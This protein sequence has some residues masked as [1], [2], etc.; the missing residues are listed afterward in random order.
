MEIDLALAPA[1]RMTLNQLRLKGQRSIHFAKESD[2]RRMNILKSLLTIPS[3]TTCY[4]VKGL[5]RGSEGAARQ[6]CVMATVS[7]LSPSEQYKVIF[8]LDENFLAADRL[9]LGRQLRSRQNKTQV[10]FHHLE[11]YQ[12][13]L[14][15][16]PDAFAWAFAR[17]GRWRLALRSLDLRI[18]HLP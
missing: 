7:E 12:E 4:V 5:N 2:S 3:I 14:L 8:D 18:K 16:L 1:A 10:I 6:L 11:P 15:A 17:G 9:T 13:Q